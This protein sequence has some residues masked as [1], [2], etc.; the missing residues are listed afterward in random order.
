MNKDDLI[1]L[2]KALGDL[3]GIPVRLFKDGKMIF[4]HSLV[5]LCKDPFALYEEEILAVSKH[6]GY[7]ITPSFG[8]YGILNSGKFK[9]VIGPTR[10]VSMSSQEIKELAIK[11]DVASEDLSDFTSSMQS[12]IS[13]PL[14]SL[15]QTLCTTNFALNHEK[16]GLSD[17][18][19]VDSSQEELHKELTEQYSSEDFNVTPSDT[20]KQAVDG[21]NFTH[22][23]MNVENQLMRIIQNGNVETLKGWTDNAPAV[24]PGILSGSQLRQYKNIFIVSATLASRAAIKG[25]LSEDISFRLSDAYIQKCELLSD[26]SL[27]QN[28]QY[29]MILDYTERVERIRIGE[30]P[31]ELALGVAN[32]V[33]GHLYERI[34]VEDIA[35]SLYISKSRLFNRFKADTGL[36]IYDYILKEKTEEAKRLLRFTD[37]SFSAISVL[38]AFSSQSHFNRVFLKY[39]GLTPS[40]Y[41]NDS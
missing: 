34:S 16:L 17:I 36:T 37:K 4:F 29:H 12:I 28:L 19:I 2:S 15:M 26:A 32:Y 18:V 8:Y 21:S 10:Q 3:T 40:Q 9:I 27:I 11:L 33:S 24:R 30:H 25:G 39:A 22:N 6:I 13:F 38:L 1:Y 5:P 14:D 7:F 23:S 41:R 31:T 20:Y 35:D